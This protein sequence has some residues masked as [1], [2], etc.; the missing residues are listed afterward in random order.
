MTSSSARFASDAHV[1]RYRVT[2]TLTKDRKAIASEAWELDGCLHRLHGPALIE[3]SEL[4]GKT[5]CETWYSQGLEHRENGPAII[6]YDEDDGEAITLAVWKW[7]GQLHR[8]GGPAVIEYGPSGE[9]A[10]AEWW[11][12]GKKIKWNVFE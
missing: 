5:L 11:L 10:V 4:T 9:I 1:L 2:T 6:E 8:R 3:I 7:H 12:H